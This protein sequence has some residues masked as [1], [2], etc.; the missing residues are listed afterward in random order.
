MIDNKTIIATL[1]IKPQKKTN[2][3]MLI[4]PIIMDFIGQVLDCEKN[5]GVNI[6]H[7]YD[8]KNLYLDGYLNCIDKVL[9]NYD[10]LF[11][12][13]THT[14]ELMDTIKKLVISGIIETKVKEKHVCSCGKID[15]I[16]DDSLYNP[17]LFTIQNDDVICNCCKTKAK[18][19]K[20]DCLVYNIKGTQ[21]NFPIVPSYLAKEIYEFNN[22]FSNTEFLVNKERETGY[23]IDYCNKRYNIDIDFIWMNY[24]NLFPQRNQI[25]IA[26]NHQLFQMY[27]MYDII[28]TTSDKNAMFIANPYLNMDI[29]EVVD[30]MDKRELE[31]FKKLLLMY[32]LKWKNKDC[33][34][35]NGIY[36]FLTNISE[37]KLK[38]LY[39]T[40]IISSREQLQDN[41][42][43]F[44][45]ENINN[46][47]QK[48]TNMQNNIKKMKIL[49]N[50]GKL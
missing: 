31:E 29:H 7:S 6:L 11:I 40:M 10:S 28:K 39:N 41:D 24:F 35:D 32:N 16:K 3:G 46:I 21:N 34:W 14:E 12:D 42:F 23:Y 5:L 30:F 48:E 37:M 44:L 1:P 43:K 9:I 18:I 47:L 36:E 17:K 19:V 25:F 13:E 15:M 20:M 2:A 8:N 22:K 26:S 4:A 45:H 27:L 38:N 50:S 49:Y 33:N